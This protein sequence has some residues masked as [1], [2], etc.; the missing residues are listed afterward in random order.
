MYQDLIKSLQVCG[1]PELV[2]VDCVAFHD[3]CCE[4]EP[5]CM[6]ELMRRAAD[7]IDT[8]SNANTQLSDKIAHLEADAVKSDGDTPLT[9]NA[10]TPHWVPVAERLPKQKI[11]PNTLDFEYVLCA[12]VFGDVRPYKFGK[13]DGQTEAHFW[14]GFGYVD[15]Y[16]T[17]WMSLPDHPDVK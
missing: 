9:E 8:L 2:H 11:N 14:N 3:G 7:A 5:V 4:A 6:Y 12:T 15:A 16:V 13:R 1:T 17:H 10:N